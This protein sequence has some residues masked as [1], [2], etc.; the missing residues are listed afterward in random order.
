MFTCEELGDGPAPARV[1]ELA[2][3]VLHDEAASSV[4]VA[5]VSAAAKLSCANDSIV[6]P[7]PIFPYL[8]EVKGTDKVL[9]FKHL[10]AFLWPLRLLRSLANKSV[11]QHQRFIS[12]KFSAAAGGEGGI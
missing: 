11:L 7:A 3:I 8:K 12:G 6:P 9:S 4:P 10:R 1:Y 5:P 2:G